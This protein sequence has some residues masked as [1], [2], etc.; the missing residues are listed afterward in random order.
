M[1]KERLENV[2]S[3][4]PRCETAI[5]GGSLVILFPDLERLKGDLNTAVRRIL[6]SGGENPP[7]FD[8]VLCLNKEEMARKILVDLEPTSSWFKNYCRLKL[9]ASWLRSHAGTTYRNKKGEIV[10]GI[11]F[12]N[13][14]EMICGFGH[15]SWE[16]KRDLILPTIYS[17]WRHERTHA[18]RKLL[19]PSGERPKQ[20]SGLTLDLLEQEAIK[21]AK[22]GENLP[23]LFTLAFEN[24]Y[25]L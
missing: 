17:V 23:N 20:L 18:A 24:P 12:P 22:I 6:P 7:P 3:P 10:V 5:L 19:E 15:L 21:V 16:A 4:L 25:H 1:T 9:F 14:V 2:F 11:Y 13:I 8:L